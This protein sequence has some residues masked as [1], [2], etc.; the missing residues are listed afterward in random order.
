MDCFRQALVF[1][2]AFIFLGCGDNTP[3]D[4]TETAIAAVVTPVV[5]DSL[6]E[7]LSNWN[8]AVEAKYWEELTTGSW[9]KLEYGGADLKVSDLGATREALGE[10]DR[11]WFE[12]II[13][14]R[15]F[16]R[17]PFSISQ[18]RG[19]FNIGKIG[20]IKVVRGNF[21][22][23]EEWNS[24]FSIYLGDDN[25][26]LANETSEIDVI[27]EKGFEAETQVDQIPAITVSSRNDWGQR[28]YVD[29]EGLVLAIIDDKHTARYKIEDGACFEGFAKAE[30]FELAS[31]FC[32]DGFWTLRTQDR[33]RLFYFDP[34]FIDVIKDAG[35][36]SSSLEYIIEETAGG[37]EYALR[38]IIG[39][40]KGQLIEPE[41]LRK[42]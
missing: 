2:S 37:V 39:D 41:W 26:F 3:A 5:Y 30:P 33:L 31:E 19:Y 38:T 12:E 10:I 21:N 22:R 42:Q 7:N 11:F 4:I 35:S 15:S 13:A 23:K 8:G 24:F 18:N 25:D 9:S 27:L 1:T 29:P 28:A 6:P 36:T 40:G 14:G 32:R 16:K 34:I 17:L 20:T